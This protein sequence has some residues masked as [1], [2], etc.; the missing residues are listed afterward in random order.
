MADF[1]ISSR[2]SGQKCHFTYQN[3]L[4]GTQEWAE[5]AVGGASANCG[6]D[7]AP[8]PN[9]VCC[10]DNGVENI[11][12]FPSLL[13]NFSSAGFHGQEHGSDHQQQ[14]VT[15]PVGDVHQVRVNP[16]VTGDWGEVIWEMRRSESSSGPVSLSFDRSRG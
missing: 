7:G 4:K 3:Y 10:T 16:H 11:S 6:A 8:N 9:G 1:I 14:L 5:G 12:P 15:H 2:I 13:T